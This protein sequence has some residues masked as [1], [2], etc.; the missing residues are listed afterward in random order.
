MGSETAF[1][2]QQQENPVMCYPFLRPSNPTYTATRTYGIKTSFRCN[3]LSFMAR[4]S[5]FVLL[6]TTACPGLDV[7]TGYGQSQVSYPFYKDDTLVRKAYYDEASKIHAAL[8][9]N[10]AKEHKEDYKKIYESRFLLVKDLFTSARSVTAPVAN[11]YLQQVVAKIVS[12]NPELKPLNMRVVF[13]RDW[14]PNA[15]SV[16]EGTI[17]IN[18]GLLTYLDS[19]AQLVF[20]LCHEIAHYYLDHSGSAIKKY[21]ETVNDDAFQKE[22]RRLNRQQYRVNEQLE[23]LAKDI[24]F[25]SRKHSRN[26]EAAADMQAYRFMKRAGYDCNAIVST[27][28]LLDKIDDSSLFKP[29]NVEQA[30]QF[31]TFPFK[32]RWIQKESTIF[33]AVDDNSDRSKKEQDSLKTHP[34]C[35][36]RIA[37]LKDSITAAGTA[38][39]QSL[40]S[41]AVFQQLKKDFIREITEFC[42][43]EQNLSRNLYYSLL[44]L[45]SGQETALA[46]YSIA[47][48]LNQ[49]YVQQRDHSLGMHID[50]EQKEYPEDY[51]ILLRMLD[52]LRLEDLAAINTNFCLKHKEEMKDYEGFTK[53]MLKAMD[54]K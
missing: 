53:E 26:N 34:D 6:L 7:T 12:A 14:W 5:F 22:L 28:E 31:E 46:R 20:A 54:L 23:A 49:I 27:L 13:S 17:A 43:T 36:K 45:Q 9:K 39:K 44:L 42:F 2:R 24:A 1:T 33:S 52:K 41:D 38:G 50:H 10:L 40:V 3:Q 16:G 15:Y 19:E 47:R 4:I 35:S 37:L 11:E 48:C 21:V 29:L 32:K 8:I 30:F 25:D 51:N 18:A